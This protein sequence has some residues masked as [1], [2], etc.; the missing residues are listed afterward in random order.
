MLLALLLTVHSDG[1]LHGSNE[2]DDIIYQSV[3]TIYLPYNSSLDN[4]KNC[5]NLMS[6]PLFPNS[7]C[8]YVQQMCKAKVRLI[9]YMSF[10]L[11][12]FE[13]L[14]VC[15]SKFN[16]HFPLKIASAHSLCDYCTVVGISHCT[17]G[18]NCELF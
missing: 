6:Q 16:C 14:Q 3:D 17:V 11:C 7:T 13:K 15:Q 12:D 4:F 1:L 9:N 8:T 5:T 10:A 18:Y 2:S